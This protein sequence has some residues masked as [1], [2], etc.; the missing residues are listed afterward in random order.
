[1]RRAVE[2]VV[3]TATEKLWR[4]ANRILLGHRPSRAIQSD[5]V[6]TPTGAPREPG[7]E[8]AKMAEEE[9]P[10]HLAKAERSRTRRADLKAPLSSMYK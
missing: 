7:A 8:A 6:Q 2:Q 1:M 5:K 4:G 3:P 9:R 10:R